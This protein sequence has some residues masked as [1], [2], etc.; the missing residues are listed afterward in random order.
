MVSIG[1][2]GQQLISHHV[3]Q[4]LGYQAGGAPPPLPLV[5]VKAFRPFKGLLKALENFKGL[6]NSFKGLSNGF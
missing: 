4:V 1:S 5:V 2:P 3:V 6:Y